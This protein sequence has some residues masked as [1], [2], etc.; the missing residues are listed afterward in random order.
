MAR[1]EHFWLMIGF[2]SFFAIHIAQVIR[3]G[4]DNFRSR[5][6]GYSLVRDKEA[7]HEYSK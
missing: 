4:C 7:R 6:A 2:V 1:R 3:A 5:V